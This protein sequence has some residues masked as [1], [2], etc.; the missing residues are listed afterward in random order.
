LN[1][2]HFKLTGF[3]AIFNLFDAFISMEPPRD[4]PKE[5]RNRDAQIKRDHQIASYTT[6]YSEYFGQWIGVTDIRVSAA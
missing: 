5:Y 6:K 3:A 2:P 4:D 1:Q